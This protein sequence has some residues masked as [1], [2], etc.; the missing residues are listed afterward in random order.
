MSAIAQ[1]L[2]PTLREGL[3]ATQAGG[4]KVPGVG[5]MLTVAGNTW[6]FADYSADRA[7]LLNGQLQTESRPAWLRVWGELALSGALS[8]STS[9]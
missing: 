3:V 8:P 5:G 7:L 6:T 2:L 1:G 9:P 4:G